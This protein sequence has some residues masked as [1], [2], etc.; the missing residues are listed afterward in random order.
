MF[1]TW[2]LRCSF[3]PESAIR[4]HSPRPAYGRFGATPPLAGT[5]VGLGTHGP[6]SASKRE[7]GLFK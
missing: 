1:D 7:S 4:Q 3:L 5:T 6:D 2:Q